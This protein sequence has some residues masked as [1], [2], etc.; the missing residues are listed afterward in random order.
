MTSKIDQW[1]VLAGLVF[2]GFGLFLGEHMGRTGD[3]S[4]M[5]TH[6]HIMLAGW[7]FAALYGLV[8]RAWPAMKAGLVPVVQFALHVFGGASMTGALFVYVAL[9]GASGPHEIAIIAG[10]FAILAGW[11]LFVFQF[12]RRVVAAPKAA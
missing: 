8:Y 12:I 3:H 6:A 9:Q 5:P 7:V 1:F 11:A 10:V 2:A 4:Q